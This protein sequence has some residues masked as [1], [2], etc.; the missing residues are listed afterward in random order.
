MIQEIAHLGILDDDAIE[1]DI[2]ALEI[3]ALDHPGIALAGYI[4]ALGEIAIELLAGSG[5][6][7]G[8]AEQ[9]HTLARVIGTDYGFSGDRNTYDDPANADLISVMDRKR[10]MP[11]AL[12]VIYVGLGRRVGWSVH[13]L[14]TPGHVLVSVVQDET[15][16]IDP[17]HGGS[18]VSA[19]QLA[20]LLSNALGRGTAPAAEHLAPMSNRAILIR[21]LMNQATRAESADQP[22]RA[23]EIYRRITTI[24]PAHAHGWWERARL[25]L[26]ERNIP[27]ARGSLSA[28][29]ET[30]RDPSLRAQVN[31]ALDSLA[32]A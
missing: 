23:L 14:N 4:D 17:F 28:M 7:R 22:A 27:A 20:S 2:A 1:V 30:T 3:A 9:A 10:G 29:L 24:A 19:T 6:A 25:E 15:V 12:S 13:A 18:R 16:L 31:A 32:G 5:L 21:L 26:V 11:V 8:A